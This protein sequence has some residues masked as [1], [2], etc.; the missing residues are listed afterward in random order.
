MAD[1]TEISFEVDPAETRVLDGYC[2]AKNLK[3]TQVMRKILK[4][5]SEEKHYEAMMVC[6]VA[7]NKP[8][9]TGG[10]RDD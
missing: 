2:S 10:N 8:D 6:R 5:W 1:R 3:R 9:V 7:G 4:E